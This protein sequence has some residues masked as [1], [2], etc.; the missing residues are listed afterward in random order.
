M[1][2]A[3]HCY[4]W[5]TILFLPAPPGPGSTGLP[6]WQAKADFINMVNSSQTIILVGE[7]GSGKTTQIAQVQSHPAGRWAC[8]RGGT[9]HLRCSSEP[10]VGL[11][12]QT[13]KLCCGRRRGHTP[14]A[15]AGMALVASVRV[16]RSVMP[17][18]AHGCTAPHRRS[19]PPS[20]L[21]RRA[22]ARAARRLCARSRAEWLPCRWRAA[23]P[24]RWTSR[25]G[26]RWAAARA[27]LG[28]LPASLAEGRLLAQ[29][30]D[31]RKAVLPPPRDG[32]DSALPGRMPQ[33]A[34]CTLRGPCLRAGW[35]LHPFRGVLRPQDH[36]QVRRAGGAG[37]SVCPAAGERVRAA[38]LWAACAAPAFLTAH[39]ACVSLTQPSAPRRAPAGLPPTACCCARP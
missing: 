2:R 28:G 3:H 17:A 31:L 21:P 23:L 9:V 14:T 34:G 22:T 13:G 15:A 12:P 6:V 10:G 20:S 11:L 36:H 8:V 29:L 1:L 32:I 7:T 38:G 16:I 37:P 26:R 5:L 33:L 27:A 24:R 35:L 19:L 4:L 30:L 39:P 25:W 18:F